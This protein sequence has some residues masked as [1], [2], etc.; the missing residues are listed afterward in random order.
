MATCAPRAARV[1]G[2]NVSCRPVKPPLVAAPRA[3]TLVD[4]HTAAAASLAVLVGMTSRQASPLRALQPLALAAGPLRVHQPRLDGLGHAL[5]I[6]ASLLVVRVPCAATPLVDRGR[7]C[8]AVVCDRWASGTVGVQAS[9][10]A[11]LVGC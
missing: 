9:M 7:Q 1:Q 3:S 11:L 10:V 5:L 2:P 8:A 4:G 6:V